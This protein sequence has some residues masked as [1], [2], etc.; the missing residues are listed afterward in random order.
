MMSKI[1]VMVGFSKKTQFCGSCFFS[2]ENCFTTERCQQC[3]SDYITTGVKSKF[4][5]KHK[6]YRKCKPEVEILKKGDCIL[7]NH[8][9][10]DDYATVY[11][12]KRSS[13]ESPD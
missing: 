13:K 3:W 7:R 5:S 9:D 12:P 2:C 4:R 8:Y 1:T 6:S 11:F 10:N